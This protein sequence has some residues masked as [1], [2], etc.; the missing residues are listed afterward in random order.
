MIVIS[1]LYIAQIV[2]FVYVFRHEWSLGIVGNLQMVFYS[3][4]V[5]LSGLIFFGES[6]SLLQGIGVGLAL[7]GVLL[8]NL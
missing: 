2:F 5:V 3:L 7:I 8:I 4:T 1:L 6:I